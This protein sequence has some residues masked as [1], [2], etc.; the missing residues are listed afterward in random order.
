MDSASGGDNGW[1]WVA[2]TRRHADEWA[3][4]LIAEGLS[5]IVARERGAFVLRVP[6]HQ[7][8]RAAQILAAYLCENR[9]KEPPAPDPVVITGV[10]FAGAAFEVTAEDLDPARSYELRRSSDGQGFAAVGAP[11]TGGT[12]HTFVDPSP[13]GE[14]ALYQIWIRN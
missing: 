10:Q 6:A 5:P 1:P 4:V 7:E 11:F 8:E 3:L 14:Q 9:R 13:E 12:S 2:P